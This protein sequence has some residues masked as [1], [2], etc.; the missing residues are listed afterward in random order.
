M[1]GKG[2]RIMALREWASMSAL[3]SSDD[4]DA[5]DKYL[6]LPKNPNQYIFVSADP[7]PACRAVKGE[8]LK[9]CFVRM[10]GHIFG[11]TI[12]Q[13]P[14]QKRHKLEGL[15]GR[16]VSCYPEHVVDA[17]L[18]K[19]K[20]KELGMSAELLD[21]LDG[22]FADELVPPTTSSDK[23]VSPTGS[24]SNTA[25]HKERGRRSRSKSPAPRCS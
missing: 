19:S 6:E 25:R 4:L 15:F 17:Y 12:L 8:F 3:E 2:Y 20:A 24:V 1:L 11:L 21:S 13:W 5:L 16:S 9:K 18:T 10:S 14:D 22:L 7:H 23:L